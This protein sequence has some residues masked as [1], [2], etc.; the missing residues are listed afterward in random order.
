[1]QHAVLVVRQCHPLAHEGLEQ[2]QQPSSELLPSLTMKDSLG[3][4]ALHSW[5]DVTWNNGSLQVHLRLPRN[6]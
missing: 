5:T 2:G 3:M 1:M 6:K 4:C